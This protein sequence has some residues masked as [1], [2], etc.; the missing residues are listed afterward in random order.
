MLIAFSLPISLTR[1]E[2]SVTPGNSGTKKSST[3]EVEQEIKIIGG[4]CGTTPE[5]IR[6]L[7]NILKN[8]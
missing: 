6:S 2:K 1:S 7:K 5:Y 4:C 3:L 8:Y